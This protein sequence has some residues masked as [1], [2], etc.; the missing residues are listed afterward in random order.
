MVGYFFGLMLFAWLCLAPWIARSTTYQ[1][2]LDA[3]AINYPWWAFFTGA[4]LFNDLGK[5]HLPISSHGMFLW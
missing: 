5:I 1:A 4:S 2:I 3:D